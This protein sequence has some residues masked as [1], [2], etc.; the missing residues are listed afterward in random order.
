MKPESNAQYFR[1][2]HDL[3]PI[4]VRIRDEIGA[5]ALANVRYRVLESRLADA[6]RD[7]QQWVFNEWSD[8]TSRRQWNAL[9]DELD[10][11]APRRRI[12][13]DWFETQQRLGR[14]TA[15]ASG[16]GP[17]YLLPD[18][19]VLDGSPMLLG[20]NNRQVQSLI[21]WHNAVT[22]KVVA[23]RRLSARLILSALKASW[24]DHKNAR[25][26]RRT[27]K[28]ARRAARVFE[29]DAATHTGELGLLDAAG[30][31]YTVQAV[32]SAGQ[33]G[34]ATTPAWARRVLELTQESELRRIEDH[35]ERRR[36]A[37]KL[38]VHTGIAAGVFAGV[39]AI[40]GWALWPVLTT[41][42]AGYVAFAVRGALGLHRGAYSQQMRV[43]V[44]SILERGQFNV[45]TIRR[46]I[47]TMRKYAYFDR[48]SSRHLTNLEQVS[49]DFLVVAHVLQDKLLDSTA[50]E[51]ARAR[52]MTAL[53]LF[54]DFLD[55]AGNALGAQ[56]Q[57]FHGLNPHGGLLGRLLNTVLA[58]TFVVNGF[59]HLHG[60]LTGDGFVFAVNAAYFL[61]D[62]LFFGQAGP[63]AVTGWAGWDVGG[64]PLVRKLVHRLALPM[65]TVANVLLALQLAFIDNS[66]MVI[67]AMALTLSS[68]YLKILGGISEGK[69][70]RLA[71]RRGALANG[72]LNGSLMSFGVITLLPDHWLQLL[73]AAVLAPFVVFGVSKLDLWRSR[74]TRAPPIDQQRLAELAERLRLVRDALEAVPGFR[75]DHN[76]RLWERE[77]AEV[78][79]QLAE[80]DRAAL[81][82][83]VPTHR[84]DRVG[85]RATRAVDGLSAVLPRVG[86]LAVEPLGPAREGFESALRAVRPIDT[87]TGAAG[88][89]VLVV[90]ASA[91]RARGVSDRTLRNVIAYTLDGRVFVTDEQ[92][93]TIREREAA[94][95]LP[96]GWW[97]EVLAHEHTYRVNRPAPGTAAD[98]VETW[99]AQRRANAGRLVGHWLRAHA[100]GPS[101]VRRGLARAAVVAGMSV[102]LVA[103]AAPPA[104]ATGGAGAVAEVGLSVALWVGTPV[105]LVAAGAAAVALVAVA[106]WRGGSKARGRALHAVFWMTGL[107]IVAG[108]VGLVAIGGPVVLDASVGTTLLPASWGVR[109]TAW[110]GVLLA[111]TGALVAFNAVLW[112]AR[113]VVSRRTEAREHLVAGHR[114]VVLER[115]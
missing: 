56:G 61:A 39:V 114:W 77:L 103:G 84:I 88:A 82:G 102:L 13:H 92:L 68:G 1:H 111:S 38:L 12:T 91:L 110:G 53:R 76:Q 54:S 60:M 71:P 27:A 2:H 58:L 65:I 57:S 115:L 99:R 8:P 80:L 105:G 30:D 70:G 29:L 59:G 69:L 95:L 4:W 45:D 43:L 24:F 18:G 46:L 78:E 19:T 23:G 31:P 75:W 113:Q 109:M 89:T 11:T 112:A 17:D 28:E 52:F 86:A 85:Q 41:T 94:G 3:D 47:E 16:V 55:R 25:D 104:A 87:V 7:V 98:E 62:L 15:T 67:P 96:S 50:G 6:Q 5:Q 79:K 37:R 34:H 97:E 26:D 74:R 40:G 108:V 33:T 63:S 20:T 48:A 73:G 49:N 90:P 72:V 106:S 93:R 44:E 42:T 107:V 35:G 10:L 21:G 36:T 83:P 101:G 66:G 9:F 22:S 32:I 14:I 51:T 64:H 81:T 100:T